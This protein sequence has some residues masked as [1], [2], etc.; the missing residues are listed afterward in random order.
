VA[1]PDLADLGRPASL[2]EVGGFRPPDDPRTSW[3]A[4][5]TVARAEEGW[6]LSEGDPMLALLQVVVEELP[7]VPDPLRDIAALTL[8]VG[9]FA[10]PVDEPNGVNWCLRAYATLDELVP[11]DPPRPARAGDPKL[12]RG[13]LTTYKPFP[14][15]WRDVID[16]PSDDSVPL[17]YQDVWDDAQQD[18]TV[19]AANRDGLKVGGWPSTVQS[20]VDWSE[21]DERLDAVDFILQVDSDEKTGFQVGYGGVLYVGRRRSS[22][23]WHCSWQ[24]M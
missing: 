11:L 17:E 8:F 16:W 23:T 9:P 12:A 10:L 14:V 4:N 1:A 20:D 22:G 7:V 2:G 5:V 6:P 15:R 3:A 24:S 21:G 19:T 13:E 18:E